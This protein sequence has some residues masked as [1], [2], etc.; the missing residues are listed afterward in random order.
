VLANTIS[1]QIIVLLYLY[2]GLNPKKLFA[3]YYGISLDS[4]ADKKK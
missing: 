4:V 1:N 2:G 3:F